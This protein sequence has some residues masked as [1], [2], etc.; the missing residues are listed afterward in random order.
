MPIHR[1][2]KRVYS[3]YKTSRI[4]KDNRHGKVSNK[5]IEINLEETS[6]LLENFDGVC[7]HCN[8]VVDLSIPRG[9]SSLSSDRI[10]SGLESY[11]SDNI[12]FCHLS[13][14]VYERGVRNK[15]SITNEDYKK[16]LTDYWGCDY[17]DPLSTIGITL[18][19]RNRLYLLGT[20]DYQLNLEYLAKVVKLTDK[21]TKQKTKNK[22]QNKMNTF[23]IF[24]ITS[25]DGLPGFRIAG[26]GVCGI[27]SELFNRSRG[28]TA[29]PESMSHSSRVTKQ[30]KEGTFVSQVILYFLTH[31]RE[32]DKFDNLSFAREFHKKTDI[33]VEF[34]SVLRR[35]MYAAL[36]GIGS[37]K[38]DG[39]AEVEVVNKGGE[40][41]IVK[42]VDLRPLEIESK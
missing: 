8:G 32:G 34:P 12:R 27:V 33:S 22:T 40:F 23:E 36:N 25:D 37:W 41:M 31:K 10:K 29:T 15:T 24:P 38:R 7:P 42:L 21:K 28:I 4:G 19:K 14:N 3:K 20:K 9:V 16:R 6:N 11:R 5:F 39:L 26:E 2:A 18:L 13:C 30:K 17:I 35:S 1:I